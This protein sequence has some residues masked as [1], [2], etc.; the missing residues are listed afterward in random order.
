MWIRLATVLE[1]EPPEL[2]EDGCDEEEADG[3]SWLDLIGVEVW[4]LRGLPALRPLVGLEFLG[5]V[6]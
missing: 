5:A 2:D 1:L 4:F 3:W 6:L